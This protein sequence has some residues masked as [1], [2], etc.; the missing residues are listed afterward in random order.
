MTGCCE[1][2]CPGSYETL[3]QPEI[4]ELDSWLEFYHNHDKYK[5][6]GRII[7]DPV[8]N[9]IAKEFGGETEKVITGTSIFDIK[10]TDGLY[11]IG[12]LR[13]LIYIF[14]ITY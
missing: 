3:T 14:S 4:A 11:D 6:V 10:K 1:A 5:Y 9:M 2:V 13:F 8:A 7:A 12:L